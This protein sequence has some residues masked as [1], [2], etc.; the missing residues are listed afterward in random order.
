M[1][2]ATIVRVSFRTQADGILGHGHDVRV[3][4]EFSREGKRIDLSPD[5]LDGIGAVVF[6]AGDRAIAHQVEVRQIRRE[7]GAGELIVEI[8][9]L[10]TDSDAAKVMKNVAWSV[11][12]SMIASRLMPGSDK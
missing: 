7:Q 1:T 10:L 11:L 5:A 8:I 12:G 4:H 6:D 3:R 2:E 9:V